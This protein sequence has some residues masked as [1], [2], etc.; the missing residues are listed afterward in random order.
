MSA[1][2]PRPAP[3]TGSAP[4]ALL[5]LALPILASQALRLAFQWVDALWVRGL[6]TSATAAITT[7]IFVLWCVISLNDVFGIGLSA[8][9]SQ[10]I[11]A[12]ERRRA[13]VAAWKGL[14]A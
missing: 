10:L 6:G 13:G 12:G 9:V 4:R 1:D 2:A 3:L 8:Y 7:S 14:R 11:G 5:R